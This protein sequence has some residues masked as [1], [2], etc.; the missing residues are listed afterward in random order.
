MSDDSSFSSENHYRNHSSYALENNP[1]SKKI[2]L[3][4][5]FSTDIENQN[6]KKSK[7]FKKD[8]HRT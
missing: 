8:F 2:R 5:V 1:N 7:R 4:K 3:N 6:L